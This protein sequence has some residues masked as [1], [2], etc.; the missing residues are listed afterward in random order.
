MT[1]SGLVARLVRENP[2][3]SAS[4]CERLVSVFFD[5]IA[6]HLASSGRIELR[7][8]GTFTIKERAARIGVDPRTRAPVDLPDR[9]VPAFRA[10][11][12]LIAKINDRAPAQAR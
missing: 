12:T 1:R 7:G 10:A 6:D 9:R 3:L 8:F 5:R 4:D 2:S 11:K